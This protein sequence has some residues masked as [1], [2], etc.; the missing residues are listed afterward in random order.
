MI[1]YFVNI[2]KKFL[3]LNNLEIVGNIINNIKGRTRKALI[4]LIKSG[5]FLLLLKRE[6]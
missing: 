5:I 2:N 1:K 4:G 3:V 6:I